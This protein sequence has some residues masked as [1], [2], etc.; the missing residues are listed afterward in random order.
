MNNPWTLLPHKPPYL[1]DMDASQVHAKQ[2][3]WRA[4]SS[5]RGL[6]LS[7]HPIPFQ[8]NP[9]KARV[10]VLMLNP[11]QKSTYSEPR[12]LSEQRRLNYR[13]Q[14][15]PAFVSLN[16]KFARHTG[17]YWFKAFGDLIRAVGLETVQEYVSVIQYFPYWSIDG[18]SVF[19]GLAS[20]EYSREL[21]RDAHAARKPIVLSRGASVWT[22]AVP[23]LADAI[24]MKNPRQAKISPNNLV[25]G[26][27]D[28][29]RIV[30]A[31]Q[32]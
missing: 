7:L 2:A 10:L 20:Q 12:E 32:E 15:R 27:R 6:D 13:F 28:L 24:R 23:A 22:A 17:G 1:L 29:N 19:D 5:T 8:G 3:Q 31:L 4:G 21:V 14:S 9:L 11:G 25:G 16:P 30:A 26:M 18:G